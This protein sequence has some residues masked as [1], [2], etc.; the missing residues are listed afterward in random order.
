MC[1]N[2]ILDVTFEYSERFKKNQLDK[3]NTLYLTS[4]EHSYPNV[5]VALQNDDRI[6]WSFDLYFTAEDPMM[7]TLSKLYGTTDVDVNELLPFDHLGDRT[8]SFHKLINR[9]IGE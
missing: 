5:E 2:D 1:L 7:S 4:Y 3:L 6:K 8:E 9:F